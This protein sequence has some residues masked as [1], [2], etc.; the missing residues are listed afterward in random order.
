MGRRQCKGAGLIDAVTIVAVDGGG[1]S[2]LKRCGCC[3]F[4]L[5]LNSMIEARSLVKIK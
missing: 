1:W 2:V 4:D 3:Q 5:V